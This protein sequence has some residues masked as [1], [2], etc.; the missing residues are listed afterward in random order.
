[1]IRK[2]RKILAAERR[3]G[4][5]HRLIGEEK[6]QGGRGHEYMRRKGRTKLLD[7]S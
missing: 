1:M 4:R 2:A 6:E 7:K 5:L 3:G